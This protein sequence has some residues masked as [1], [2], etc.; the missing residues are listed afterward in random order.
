[1]RRGA[2]TDEATQ[3]LQILAE[4]SDG[5]EIAEEDLRLHGPSELTGK[6]QSGLPPF[7]FGHLVEDRPFVELAPDLVQRALRPF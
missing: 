2:V 5:F 6:Q 3:R 1:M 4:T 7:C